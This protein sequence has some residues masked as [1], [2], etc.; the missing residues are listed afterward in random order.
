LNHE[1][2]LEMG[3][4]ALGDRKRILRAAAQLQ[5]ATLPASPMMPP[6][7]QVPPA[8]PAPPPMSPSLAAGWSTSPTMAGGGAYDMTSSLAAGLSAPLPQPSSMPPAPAFQYVDAPG[9]MMHEQGPP[10][11]TA[12]SLFAAPPPGMGYPLMHSFG[13]PVAPHHP[14]N[15]LFP[16]NW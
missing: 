10:P 14:S 8:W 13:N 11:P 15:T 16:P 3:V 4:H 12:D 9:M 1:D 2:L 7:M 5:V 6:S